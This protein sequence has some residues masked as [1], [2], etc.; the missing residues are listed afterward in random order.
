MYK[1]YVKILQ[2][3]YALNSKQTYTIVLF[4]LLKPFLQLVVSQGNYSSI[5]RYLFL[6]W[7]CL[8]SSQAHQRFL[9]AKSLVVGHRVVYISIPQQTV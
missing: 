8:V 4:M 2:E 1:Y 9:L 7:Q 5:S 6:V 3:S